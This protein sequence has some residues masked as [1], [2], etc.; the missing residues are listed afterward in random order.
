MRTTQCKRCSSVIDHLEVFPGNVCLT[1][2]A[3]SPAGRYIPTAQELSTAWGATI[4]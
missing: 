4:R 1:C 3:A 2:W